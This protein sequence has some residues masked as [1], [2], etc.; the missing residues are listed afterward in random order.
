MRVTVEITPR[1]SSAFELTLEYDYGSGIMDEGSWSCL[2]GHMKLS[3]GAFEIYH[4]KLWLHDRSL[5][6]WD[7]VKGIATLYQVLPDIGLLGALDDFGDWFD[8]V[9]GDTGKGLVDNS[10]G[11]PV[12]V[13]W[14]IK[15]GAPYARLE[16]LSLPAQP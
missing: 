12:G 6:V 3:D 2:P 10:G 4:G 5:G 1:Y 14:L 15:N 13:T 9:N 11:H 7:Y 16:A 8:L